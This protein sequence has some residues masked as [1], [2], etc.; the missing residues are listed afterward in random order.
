MCPPLS[1]P[2]SG[3]VSTPD[4]QQAGDE[5]VYSCGFGFELSGANRRVCL[6]TGSWS[7]VAPTCEEI[8][9]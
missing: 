6:S 1:D 3:S 9:L 7:G 8:G 4:G 5:A 2:A